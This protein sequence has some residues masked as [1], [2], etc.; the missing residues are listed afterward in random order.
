M[1]SLHEFFPHGEIF[2]R[3]GQCIFTTSKT[4][5]LLLRQKVHQRILVILGNLHFNSHFV[6]KTTKTP[7]FV[8]ITE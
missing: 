5:H 7:K 3:L 4:N 2:H 1:G 8:F 6:L